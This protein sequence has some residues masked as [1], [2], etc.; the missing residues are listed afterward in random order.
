M[1]HG[2]EMVKLQTL[3]FASW[4]D[5]IAIGIISSGDFLE[6]YRHA[7]FAEGDA[8]DQIC[9]PGY[10]KALEFLIKDYIVDRMQL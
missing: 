5:T 4:V 6:I 7:A 9:G 2:S 10:R 1:T 3:Y 8:L